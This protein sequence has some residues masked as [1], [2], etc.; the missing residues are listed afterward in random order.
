MEPAASGR[1]TILEKRNRKMKITKSQLKQII[2]EEFEEIT[3]GA[4]HGASYE[5][6]VDGAVEVFQEFVKNV[7]N[8][9]MAIEAME[10][11]FQAAQGKPY[12]SESQGPTVGEGLENITPENLEILAKAA[13]H[14]ATQ[15]AAMIALATGG[16]GAAIMKIKEL[17]ETE[18]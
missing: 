6:H 18:E 8:V 17:M 11:A 3:E 7:G 14:F 2:K 1:K 10:M 12:I 15:P 16:L 5:D 13:H 9:P 4:F